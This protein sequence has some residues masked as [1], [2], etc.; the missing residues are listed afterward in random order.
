M[1]HVPSPITFLHA[2]KPY[3]SNQAI[4]Y[5]TVPSYDFIL[6]TSCIQEFISDHKSYFS[7]QTLQ[8]LF[9]RAGYTILESNHLNNNNDLEI[10]VQYTPEDSQIDLNSYYKY[11]KNLTSVIDSHYLKNQTVAIWGAGHRTLTLLSQINHQ[12]ISYVVDSAPFKQGLYTPS[13]R[14]P[15]ISP[16]LYQTHLTDVLIISLPGIFSTE[17]LESIAEWKTRPSYTYLLDESGINSFT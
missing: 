15:I 9:I 6:R 10:L 1:E 7:H 13:S 14:I 4:L 12:A 2:I 8:S 3:L 16:T 17:V 5:F 11:L